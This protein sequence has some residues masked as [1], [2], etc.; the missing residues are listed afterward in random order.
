MFKLTRAQ[1]GKNL[2]S[3][4]KYQVSSCS[5]ALFILNPRLADERRLG[6]CC[7]L[8]RACV[9]VAVCA[10]SFSINKISDVIYVKGGR[11]FFVLGGKGHFHYHW[12]PNTVDLKAAGAEDFRASFMNYS[13][14]PVSF[15]TNYWCLALPILCGVRIK[16]EERDINN[17][18]RNYK[19][20]GEKS[21]W[22]C[23]MP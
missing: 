22:S 17:W 18:S 2:M 16:W 1:W 20:E 9:V 14:P 23:C 12:F 19:L 15:A 8:G 5:S 7:L 21:S 4:A 13:R 11:I 3:H 10:L 6:C